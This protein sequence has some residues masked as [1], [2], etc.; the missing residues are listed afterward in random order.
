MYKRQDILK[1]LNA[2][3][4]VE[5]TDLQ[6]NVAAYDDVG[7]D[8]LEID[9]KVG[10]DGQETSILSNPVT[11]RQPPYSISV[12]L[13]A[14][15]L[16]NPERNRV[17]VSATALDTYGAAHGDLDKHQ[18][19]EEIVARLVAD[20]PPEVKIA[21][22]TD[23][24]AVTEGEFVLV[25]ITAIDDVGIDKVTLN[26]QNLVGGDKVLT[27]VTFP[28]E[29]LLELPYGQAGNALELTAS[30]TEQRQNGAARTVQALETVTLVVNEDVDPPTLTV[31]APAQISP[32]PT[33]A[34]KRFFNYA[35]TAL[36]D[37]RVTSVK[38][39]LA[40]DSNNDGLFDDSEIKHT[41]VLLAPPYSGA[42]SVES[43]EDY[44]DQQ[45]DL[46]PLQFTVIAQDGAGN[47][48]IVTR[49]LN[50]VRNQPPVVTGFQVLD[51][52]G[53]SL[54]AVQEM[55][56][57]REFI[58]HVLASD[59]EVGVDSV[60]LYRATG[61]NLD[62]SAFVAVAS[63]GAAPFQFS[64]TAPVGQIGQR[65]V[66]KAIATDVDG[67][68][69]QLAAS[70]AKSL[71]VKQD[72]PPEVT[73]VSPLDGAVFI[74]GQELEVTARTRDDLGFNGIDRVEFYL[75]DKLV[76]T[77]YQHDTTNTGAASAERHYCLLYTSDAADED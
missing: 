69:S 72:E 20:V 76:T 66:Y 30:A 32:L 74:E 68:V 46:L 60:T 51:Q 71:T 24:T 50:L 65:I 43:I 4:V 56:E 64:E 31:T 58:V 8:S 39:Q 25:Q 9:V 3:S 35:I 47:Q 28:Y 15:D 61:E 23:G 6:I 19:T 48:S 22:P 52:R 63:D 7:I 10:A 1:P 36:D 21:T 33:V 44:T 26:V 17:V 53:Q 62:L 16:V 37:V 75:N 13:P 45:I 54:G 2:A 38:L 73:I 41:K 55:T 5:G 12:R 70:P 67:K 34:E 11:L 59:Q 18:A 42:M 14:A 29:F 57:G 77:V 40:A 27:D 49:A